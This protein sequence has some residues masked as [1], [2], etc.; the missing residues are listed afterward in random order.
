[1][2][3]GRDRHQFDCTDR[4]PFELNMVGQDGTADGQARAT[5][6]D[7]SRHRAQCFNLQTQRDSREHLPEIAQ[8]TGR[9]LTGEHNVDHQRYFAFKAGMEALGLGQQMIDSIGY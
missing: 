1:M 2:P 3:R 5:I 6:K 9:D 8:Y 4:L 7:T